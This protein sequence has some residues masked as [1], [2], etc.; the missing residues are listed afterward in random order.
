M[1]A[2]LRPAPNRGV[3][4][5]AVDDVRAD[6]PATVE[7]AEVSKFGLYFHLETDHE[8]FVRQYAALPYG[9]DSNIVE[10]IIEG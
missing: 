3:I 8:G 7:T 10:L 2:F 4:E 9:L 5:A 6:A 1:G